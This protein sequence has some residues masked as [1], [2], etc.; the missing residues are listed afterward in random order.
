[1]INRTSVTITA[2][3][4]VIFILTAPALP[5]VLELDDQSELLQ[6]GHCRE[7]NLANAVSL[8][9]WIKPARLG[10][11][12]GRIIDK[13]QSGTDTGYMLDTYPGNSLR[14]IVAQG[15]LAYDA[16]LPTDKWS[17]VA[18]V[19]SRTDNIYKLY[20]N[21]KEV[22]SASQ[23]G[24]KPMD[25]NRLPLRIGS[26][27]NGENRYRG[28]M[29]RVTIYRCALTAEEV[30]KLASDES[31][32]SLNLS[33]RV[34]DWDFQMPIEQAKISSA[35][36]GLRINPSVRLTGQAGPPEGKLTLWYRKP[37]SEW[38]QALAI[39]NGR[40]GAMV[41]GGVQEERIQ[42]NE[43]TLWGGGPYDPSSSSALEA[44][45]EARRLVFEGKYKDAERL[46]GRRMMARP[47]GQMPY[48][49][50]GSLMLT[51]NDIA[52]V[53]NYRR[54]LN[55][56][57]AIASVTYEADGAK[58]TREVFSSPVDQVIVVRLTA[59]KPGRISFNAGMATPQKAAVS[60][61]GSDTL[62][63][64]GTNGSSQG[65]AGAL[66]FQA[67]VKVQTEGGK[68]IADGE[69]IHVTDADS[70]TIF[71]AANTSY[72][73][74]KDVTGDPEALTKDCIAKASGKSFDTLRKDHV[75]EHQRLFHRVKLDLGTTEAAKLPTDQRIRESSQNDDPQ[76]AAL[77]FQFGRY[78]L[79]SC[80]RPG[81]QPANLQGIWNDS[82]SPPWSSKYTIN[83]NTEMNYW[84]AEP[85]NLGEC[86]EPLIAMVMDLT[87]TGARTAKVNWGASGWLCHHNT[88]L[89]RATAP[90]DGPFW[91]FWPTGGA[92]LSK[93]LYEHYEFNGDKDFLKK[94]YPALKGAS[95]FFLDTLV[96]EPTHK[97]L[98]TCPSVSPENG[99]KFGTSI[100]AGP[101]MDNQIIR[102]LFSN[103]ISATEVLGVDND[104]REKLVAT[105]ARLAL[106][107]IGKEGQL[108]EWLEDW[109]MEAGDIHH[110]HVSHL[111]GF[112]PSAQITL[113]G[114]PD[115][116]KAVRKSLEIRGDEATGWGIGW[117]L[118]LWAR[119]QD[120]EHT[121]KI[122]QM[123]LRPQRTYPNMFDAHPPFQID[124]NF[125]GTS[126]ICEMLLQSHTGEL[127]LLPTLPK[128]WPA[129][130]V[131]GLR[132]KGG[133]ELDIAWKDGKLTQAK[134]RS[135]LGN[136]C[137]IRYADKTTEV[138]TK[139]N[140]TYTV[141][142]KLN[143]N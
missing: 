86:V 24:M 111:Y 84:P 39:G 69:E 53:T 27:S 2:C 37:A 46:V 87:E 140:R 82:M 15:H 134:F 88:D 106:N 102:D 128:A 143:I 31:H 41:F 85:T 50:V 94:I 5:D 70:A 61:E 93:H 120:A 121:H 139:A 57:T 115:L 1:M 116:A 33:G 122:L 71:V 20:L 67:R 125:G 63:M 12:G 110:R 45:P 89:W 98:V 113:R 65:I 101:T 13:S 23:P 60:T 107:Q 51:V 17:H 35:R 138:N 126:G 74:Y 80:S 6:V 10:S 119:L 9:A 77:Y 34:A 59:D 72:K 62:V 56:D 108:Q 64:T 11:G 28:Q 29:H 117:R 127:E 92:W 58:F 100:C 91:G 137:K 66:K 136:N 3:I 52:T 73:S 43:D 90:V 42:L 141:D 105:K 129:G 18:G 78:L 16:K 25:R 36:G 55:L 95:Q 75:A 114:T 97:W 32:K 44:L 81:T 68:T 130:S 8:E 123:L 99:H 103:C 135:L 14:M 142:N 96:E 4:A 47:L 30:A 118:N 109:D 124:G 49:T 131:T 112:H 83:I 38:T 7:L 21:G 19:F 79:I 132:A 48:Q 40:L 22:A 104:F 26:C 133:F 54:D 76:L